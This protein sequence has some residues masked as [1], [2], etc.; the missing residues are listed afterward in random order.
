VQRRHQVCK[1]Q[2]VQLFIDLGFINLLYDSFLILFFLI[3]FFN[4]DEGKVK[5]RP[6]ATPSSTDYQQMNMND[7]PVM[8]NMPPP[9]ILPPL[10][11]SSGTSNTSSSQNGDRKERKRKSRWDD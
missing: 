5:E 1:Y 11:A 2:G 3:F 6:Q 4:K 7:A 9:C 10:S 8:P